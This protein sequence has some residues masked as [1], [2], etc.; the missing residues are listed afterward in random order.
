[1]GNIRTTHIGCGGLAIEEDVSLDQMP[2]FLT[3]DEF[4]LTCLTCLE[5]ITDRSDLNLSEFLGQ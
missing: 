1:M 4:S 3:E 5:E 2:K